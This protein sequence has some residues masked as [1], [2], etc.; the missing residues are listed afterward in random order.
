M[1]LTLAY[2]QKNL[3]TVNTQISAIENQL[4]STLPQEDFQEIK[5]KNQETLR[6][7]QQ[8][9]EKK[10]R[11]KFLRD[12][13]D[14]L[15]NRVYQWQDKQR[16][17]RRQ[18]S[19]SSSGS[20][21]SRAVTINVSTSA[22]F[23]GNNRGQEKGRRGGWANA[24]GDSRTQVTTRSQGIPRITSSHDT[25]ALLQLKD[26]GLRT[27]SSFMPPKDK[28]IIETFITLVE[29]DMETFNHEIHYQTNLTT[30]EKLAL[31]Q[32]STDKSLVIKP[33]DK[34]GAI[35]IMDKT[36]YI[37][38]SV[39]EAI[40]HNPTSNIAGKILTVVDHH[41]HEGTIDQKLRNYLIK[42]DPI[43]PF[44]YI[45]P[46][47]HKSLHKPPGCPIVSSTDSVLSP[48]AKTLERIL[49]PL[50]KQ[51][52]S[53]LLDTSEFLKLI[54]NLSP[55]PTSTILATWNVSSLYTSIT[56]TKGMEATDQLLSEANTDPK[57]RRFCSDILGLVL[58]ANHFMF[59]DTF[60]IQWQGTVMG[61]NV[62]P[63]YA[64]AY[65][66]AFEEDYVFNHPL[67]RQYSRTW[68]RFI[69][70][71]FCVWD[72]PLFDTYINN[73]WPEL[74]FTLQHNTKNISFLDTMVFKNIDGTLSTD[75]YTKTTDRN[76]LQFTSFH[77][78]AVKKSIPIS[79]FQRVE[80]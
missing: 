38:T 70:D 58:Q 32:L 20:T 2:L 73:I 54:R 51:T 16:F 47:V 35:V 43:I 78:L 9:L 77:P 28:P 30:E 21:D 4:S 72:G 65:M 64:V 36:D 80:R 52:K 69:D 23:L 57:I 66:A 45:L 46:K 6:I 12:T 33:A 67:F 34:C 40:P 41:L 27:P 74:K 26:L 76:S 14:Y 50:T 10:K 71:I 18:T 55:L 5:S 48:L 59:Q 8:E 7:H 19:Q 56:H 13:E 24:T 63:P 53:F 68:R 79:Q 37:D 3:D 75:L 17:S 39:Y 62:A 29:R 25:P 15:Q 22:P 60:Y 49:T 61:S 44:F 42:T 31:D 11:S 1:T